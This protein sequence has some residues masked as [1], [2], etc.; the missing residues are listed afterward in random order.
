MQGIEFEG[1][2]KVYGKPAHMTDEECVSL[3]VNQTEDTCVM[4]GIR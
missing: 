3:P 2:N 4:L 1:Q